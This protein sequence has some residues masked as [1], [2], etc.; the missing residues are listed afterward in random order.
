MVGDGEIVTYD[1][2]FGDEHRIGAGPDPHLCLG[3]VH[4]TLCAPMNEDMNYLRS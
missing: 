2:H 4:V 3:R 1:G